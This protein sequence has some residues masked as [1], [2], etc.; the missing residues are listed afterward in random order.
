MGRYRKPGEVHPGEI[1]FAIFKDIVPKPVVTIRQD[2]SVKLHQHFDQQRVTVLVEQE[3]I[4]EFIEISD[5]QYAAMWRL[6]SYAMYLNATVAVTFSSCCTLWGN[7]VA[8]Y[9]RMTFEDIM[10]ARP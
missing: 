6:I 10:E 1:V 3:D 5:A 2:G 9:D 4:D 8:N 7:R